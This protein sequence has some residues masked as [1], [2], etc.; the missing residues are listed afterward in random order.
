[1]HIAS[2]SSKLNDKWMLFSLSIYVN[3][4][5]GHFRVFRYTVKPV[6]N[7]HPWDPKIAAVVDR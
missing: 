1:M 6:Y 7:D 4:K 5:I 2:I 3:F